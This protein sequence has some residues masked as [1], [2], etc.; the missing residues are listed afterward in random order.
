VCVWLKCF[1]VCGDDKSSLVVTYFIIY[2]YMY[3]CKIYNIIYR[4]VDIDIIDI[5]IKAC[6]PIHRI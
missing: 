6:Q 2:I 1:F 4:D 3:I 5:D